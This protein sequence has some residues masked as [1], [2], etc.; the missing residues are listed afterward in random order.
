VSR[1]GPRA[2]QH[3]LAVGGVRDALSREQIGEIVGLQAQRVIDRV[4]ERG[5]PWHAAHGDERAESHCAVQHPG[6]TRL[7]GFR[8]CTGASQ[9]AH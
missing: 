4:A 2:D 8:A 1:A 3:G 6:V 9:C 7:P 5:I